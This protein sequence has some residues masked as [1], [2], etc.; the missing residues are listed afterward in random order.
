MTD[1][2]FLLQDLLTVCPKPREA[3]LECTADGPCGTE[4]SL[5][6]DA[7]L[8]ALLSGPFSVQG[9]WMPSTASVTEPLRRLGAQGSQEMR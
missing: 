1:L 8:S 9:Y 7:V 5:K 4:A 2:Y 3:V 6:D